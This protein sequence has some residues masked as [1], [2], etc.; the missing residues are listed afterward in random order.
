MRITLIL[1][2]SLAAGCG[3]TAAMSAASPSPPSACA[4]VTA[5]NAAHHGVSLLVLKRG[6]VVCED[7]PNGGTADQTHELASGTKSF[8]GLIAAAAV[9]DGFLKLDELASDTLSEWKSDPLKAKVTVRHLLSLTSGIGKSGTAA[10]YA[11]AMSRPMMREPGAAWE[12]GP[13]SFQVFGEIMKRKL[14][15]RGLPADPLVYLQARILDPIG[16]K[17]IGWGRTTDGDPF[18]PH[19]AALTAREWAKVGEFVRNRGVVNGIARVDPVAFADLFKSPPSNPGYG[20]SWW[21][22]GKPDGL[23]PRGP[24]L[25]AESLSGVPQDTAMAAG[26]GDQKLYVIPSL[27][28]TAVRQTAKRPKMERRQ[29][30]G[31]ANWSDPDFLRLVGVL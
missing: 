1:L 14:A 2:A 9:Q 10:T 15:H 8:T 19:G 5:Y 20:L 4:A 7:Y 22:P 25:S 24:G 11:F 16:V 6:K 17:P 13:G 3:T 29:D 30:T 27:G 21:L 28:L 26:A 18:M 12:Y 23:T 31:T